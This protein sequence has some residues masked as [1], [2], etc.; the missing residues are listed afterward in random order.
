MLYELTSML[1]LLESADLASLN[2]KRIEWRVKLSKYVVLGGTALGIA[3]VLI[4]GNISAY[5]PDH[6]LVYEPH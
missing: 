6:N 2:V 4:T 3:L 1:R 5:N